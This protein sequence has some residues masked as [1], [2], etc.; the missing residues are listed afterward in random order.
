M[1]SNLTVLLTC[2]MMTFIFASTAA[3]AGKQAKEK[4]A[5]VSLSG[6]VGMNP[7]PSGKQAKEKAADVSWDKCCEQN[8]NDTAKCQEMKNVT[9]K[10]KNTGTKE[11]PNWV[12]SSCPKAEPAAKPA[13]AKPVAKPADAKPVAKPADA[14]PVAKPADAKP[15]AK[16]ADAKPVA[17]PAD[18]KPVAKPADAKPVAEPKKE[19]KEDKKK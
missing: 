1:K 12:A 9:D 18:A 8:N 17:K 19:M 5:D 10:K 16:P 7:D 3:F 4:T 2:L 6:W 14:K 15:V 13:D 11:K